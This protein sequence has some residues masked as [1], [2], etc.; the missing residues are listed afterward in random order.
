MEGIGEIIWRM[1]GAMKDP[2][3]VRNVLI[4]A[5]VLFIAANVL[6]AFTN[7]SPALGRLSAYNGL[8]PGR[9]RL[10]YGDRP[11]LAYNLS[12]F[13]L[14]AMFASHEIASGRK[15]AD[16]FRVVLIGDSSTWGFLLRPE[17]TLSALLNARGLV[18]PSGKQVRVFNLGYPTMSLTKDLLMLSRALRYQPDLILWLVTLESFPASKQLAS[19][20]VQHNPQEVRELIAGSNLRLDADSPEFVTLSRWDQTLIGQRRAIADWFRLQ[21]YGVLW[22][23][24]GVDQVYPEKYDPPQ[25]NLTA[26]EVFYGLEPPLLNE[27]DLAFDALEAGVKLAGDVPVMFVNE[28]IYL[29]DG[30]NSDIRYNFYYPRWIYDQYRQ[31]MRL[32]AEANGWLYLDVW[33][34]VPAGEF[35][36]SA[37]HLTPVGENQLAEQIS[38]MILPLINER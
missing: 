29:S 32:R 11:D 36:N 12:L 25:R 20:I 33:N 17:D 22:S 13:N 19:P 6:F 15:P 21:L 5:L 8:F 26:E 9:L 2:R 1:K 37:I 14:D 35:T 30:Q 31:A 10:P 16:E 7:P 28:P 34:L 18:T 23:A 24:T 3:F 38:R 27:S 4:K